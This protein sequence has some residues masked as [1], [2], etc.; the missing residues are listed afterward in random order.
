MKVA[1]HNSIPNQ[2]S[3]FDGGVEPAYRKDRRL[4][5]L[6]E[7]NY[8]F[9]DNDATEVTGQL[10]IDL[11]ERLI[12][13]G[14]KIPSTTP[15]ILGLVSP[16]IAKK[17]IISINYKTELLSGVR[18]EPVYIFTNDGLLD[19][20]SYYHE[21]VD[22]QNNPQSKL[23]LEVSEVYTAKPEDAGL[24]PSEKALEKRTKTWKWAYEDGLLDEVNIKEKE[25]PYKTS[26]QQRRLGERRRENIISAFSD[27]VGMVLV[28]Q[29]IAT[30]AVD[31]DQK[32]KELARVFHDNLDT[33][34]IYGDEQ[35]YI[36]VA[37]D[38]VITWLDNTVLSTP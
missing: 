5:Y 29:G 18:L 6:V 1:K 24:N 33:Y 25:K 4:Y 13:S 19:K 8:D 20:T 27:N 14:A 11:T 30:D 28:L 2:D 22:E 16:A 3:L 31:A 38:T 32:L 7:D 9:T 12:N 35:I 37:N 21:Y 36:D 10:A 23:V 17:D 34:K 26:A 15:Y